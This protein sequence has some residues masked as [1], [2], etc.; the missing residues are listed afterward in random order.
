MGC[1]LINS[2]S[3]NLKEKSAKIEPEID[4]DQ[5]KSSTTDENTSL[6]C[7]KFN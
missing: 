7:S 4:E 5:T 3:I 2:N 6:N 1:I